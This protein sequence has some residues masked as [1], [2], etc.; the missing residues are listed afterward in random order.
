MAGKTSRRGFASMSLTKR[1]DI[2]SRG[3]K[4]AHA[5]GTAHEWTK[6]EAQAAGRRGG[7]A[8]QRMQQ[9]SDDMDLR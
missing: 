3:G 9:G 4:A 5:R 6:K 8:R 2:A 1:R 7:L